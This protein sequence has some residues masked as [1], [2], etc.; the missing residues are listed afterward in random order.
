MIEIKEKKD[1]CGCGA[2]VQRCPKQCISMHEDAEG[3]LYPHIDAELCIDCGLCEKI[4][5]VIN[6]NEP[7]EPMHVYAAKNP[8]EKIRLESSSGGVFTM[9]AEKIIDEGGVVFGVGFNEHWEAAHSYTETKE[10]LSAFR[11]S[12]YVQSIVG[13][14]FREAETFLK[15]GRKV[16]YTGTPCQISGLKK[17]L[18]KDYDNLLTVDFICHGTPSPGIFRWYL[19][20]VLYSIVNKKT[21]SLNL[22]LF[23]SNELQEIPKIDFLLKECNYQ[24]QNISF[25]DKSYGWKKFS[26]V[27][28]FIDLVSKNKVIIKESLDQNPF[29]QGFLRDMYLRPSCH[30]CP[31]KKLKSGSDITIGDYWNIELINPNLNDNKGISAIIV[32]TIKGNEYFKLNKCIKYDSELQDILKYNSALNSSSKHTSFRDNFYTNYKRLGIEVIAF[33]IRKNRPCIVKRICMKI[34]QTIKK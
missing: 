26:F 27:L 12:K 20:E 29:L 31:T 14:T 28:E 22:D 1:C 18:R 30:N 15:Q 33:L 7:H 13:N 10:G 32:N 21:F 6:Q 4:C 8:D 34:K 23:R 2:C 25:R 16:L 11:M 5:P 3:F 9:I 17:F 19:R 24:I